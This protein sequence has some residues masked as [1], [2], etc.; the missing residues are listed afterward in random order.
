MKR[1]DAVQ[2]TL[3][4][5][6]EVARSKWS[7]KR[8][9][10]LSRGL[11][12]DCGRRPPEENRSVCDVCG[13]LRRAARRNYTARRTALGVCGYCGR[14]PRR[15]NASYCAA[16]MAAQVSRSARRRRDQRTAVIT[17]LG[18]QCAH[19]KIA[20]ARVLTVDHI[21]RDGSARHRLRFGDRRASTAKW[22]WYLEE[23]GRGE[24]ALQLLCFNCHAIKDL[25]GHL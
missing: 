3:W 7:R 13:A 1:G 24:T 4:G 22:S 18:G 21:N 2:G 15:E 16:C 12:Q 20:D 8:R 14:N 5:S 10:R 23:I 25:T 17:I 19:C 9:A 6:G 11:C